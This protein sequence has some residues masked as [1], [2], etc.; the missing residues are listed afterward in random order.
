MTS[1][2]RDMPAPRVVPRGLQAS[3]HRALLVIVDAM[4]AI[5]ATVIALW[6]W[7]IPAGSDFS[8]SFL[9]DKLPWFAGAALWLIAAALPAAHPANAFSISRTIFVLLRGAAI[10]LLVYFAVYFYTPRGALPRLVVLYFLWEALLLTLAWRLAFV[11][12]FSRHRFRQRAIVVGSG[13]AAAVAVRLVREFH[14][15]QSDI[16]AVVLEGATPD[17]ALDGLPAI[18]AG[19]LPMVM[20]EGGVSQLILAM[21]G[22]PTG[23]LLQTLLS[24]QE[25]GV[26]IVRVQTLVEQ[27]RREV[28]V[29]LLDPDW[30]MTDLADAMRL[31]DASWWGKRALD[32]AGSIAGLV[33]A[34]LLAPF[35]ALAIRMDSR[36]PIF[37]RQQ[38]L[39]RGGLSFEL[40]KFRTMNPDA[41]QGGGAQWAGK[42]DT[43]VT[44]VGRFL[45]RTR[46]DELPQFL[47]VLRGDMSLVGPR[48]ERAAFVDRLQE[49]I[50]FY[51]ARL[52]VPPGLTG[53]AQVN[54]PYG[55]SVEL[56]QR[57]LE[58]DLYYVKHRSLVFDLAILVRTFGTVL[59][60]RG[61]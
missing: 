15:R 56:A 23:D 29:N 18:S 59:R 2:A 1:L 20:A 41:E 32:I 21:R 36:G 52:M 55:D 45:R 34:A 57:K 8:V 61:H 25:A 51:R 50:P 13:E 49:A 14:V 26:E 6:L 40:V 30:L 24:C 17:P 39:G 37:F 5:V 48:P 60:L 11:A 35:I 43:R 3:D 54:L 58:Y 53:W 28:P 4:C 38:R 16:E 7:S 9:T 22:H 46:L 33:C 19:E 27:L 10:L 31:R 42:E 12:I 44:R 47:C